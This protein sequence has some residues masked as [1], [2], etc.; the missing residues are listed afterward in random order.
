MAVSQY[1]SEVLGAPDVALP[2]VTFPEAPQEL[3]NPA[4]L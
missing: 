3:I 1:R 4:G 2:A